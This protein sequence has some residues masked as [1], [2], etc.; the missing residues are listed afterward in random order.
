MTAAAAGGGYFM[1]QY[2]FSISIMVGFPSGFSTSNRAFFGVYD[3]GAA[4]PVGTVEPSA[5]TNVVYLGFDSG[6][7]TW[8]VCAND[9]AGSATCSDLGLAISTAGMWSFQITIVPGGSSYSYSMTRLDVD[10]VSYSGAISTD[11]PV[12]T[13]AM[14]TIAWASTGALTSSVI[15][16]PSNLYYL[17][18]Y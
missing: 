2:G 14:R 9:G 17:L 4:T 18:T 15:I 5:N 8:R 11:L 3:G 12:T 1:P 16:E 13:T 7:T 6:Q 10:G